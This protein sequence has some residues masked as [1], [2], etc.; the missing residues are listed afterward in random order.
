MSDGNQLFAEAAARFDG[1]AQQEE[2]VARLLDQQAIFIR[3]LHGL[4]ALQPLQ[5]R[6]LTL[7]RQP[8]LQI[9]AHVD[10]ANYY[11][12]QGEWTQADFHFDQAE[13]L[14]QASADLAS[15]IIMVEGRVHINTIHV[16]G[17]FAAGIARLEDL[18][19]SL[20]G[21][22]TPIKTLRR[23]VCACCKACPCP[24]YVI[25]TM[26]WRSTRPTRRYD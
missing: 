18:L 8:H 1:I 24:L 23:S 5:Q 6:V 26:V 7:T 19:H 11:A 9:K 17:D 2:L 16:R 20:N 4:G 12:E 14:T 10:L 13:T 22:P 3:F 15:Y 21:A 25:A